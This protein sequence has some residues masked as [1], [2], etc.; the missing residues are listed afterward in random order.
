MEMLPD[1]NATRWKCYQME[2]LPDGNATRWKCYQM[3]MLPDGNA[4]RWKCYQMEMLPDGHETL[5]FSIE[6]S[7]WI[8]SISVGLK[9]K[10]PFVTVSFILSILG[11][12]ECFFIIALIGSLMLTESMR[13][14]SIWGIDNVATAFSKTLFSVFATSKPLDIIF[15]PSM[16]VISFFEL[17]LLERKMV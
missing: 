1:G 16:R 9:W 10:V 17:P 12:S 3:E 5:V 4:T 8:S 7:F 13:S 6:I 14:R 2:M 11:W 15:S